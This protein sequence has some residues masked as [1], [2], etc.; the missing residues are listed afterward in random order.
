M[1]Y[2]EWP[3]TEPT[4]YIENGE[5][6][7]IEYI[8]EPIQKITGDK[9]EMIGFLSGMISRQYNDLTAPD[10]QVERFTPNTEPEKLGIKIWDGYKGNQLPLWRFFLQPTK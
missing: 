3:Q 10:G 8:A 6:M 1:M 7:A 4:A 2:G 9:Y 5:V